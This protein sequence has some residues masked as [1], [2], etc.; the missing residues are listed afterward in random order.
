MEFSNRLAHSAE[1]RSCRLHNQKPLARFFHFA[2]PAV[3]RCHLRDDID[4]G[5]EAV[6]HEMVSDLLSFFFRA[7]SGENDSFVGHIK[8]VVNYRR[9]AVI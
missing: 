4:T 9:L 3:N 5:S 8:S 1:S 6:L 2:L 7:R